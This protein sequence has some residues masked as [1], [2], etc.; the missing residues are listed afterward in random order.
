MTCS[1]LRFGCSRG[2][3][4]VPKGSNYLCGLPC[5]AQVLCE[6]LSPATAVHPVTTMM[7]TGGR[8]LRFVLLLSI[9]S[10]L[11]SAAQLNVLMIAVDDLRNVGTA[12][13]EPE[14][15]MPNLEALA[16]RSTIFT[17]AY[18]QAA[19]C[20]VSRTS[21]LMARRPDT[22]QVIRNEGCPFKTQPEHA[23]WCDVTVSLF[24]TRSLFLTCSFCSPHTSHCPAL[25]HGHCVTVSQC[26][27][28]LSLA[29]SVLLSLARSVCCTVLLS[30]VCPSVGSASVAGYHCLDTSGR[31]VT[32]QWV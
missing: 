30:L 2:V 6:F 15:L 1:T 26:S 19:T 7:M 12:F 9:S 24:F 5:L 13:G 22:T 28:L 21:L 27:V 32:Q 4:R 25:R 29:R 17:N 23:A 18:A 10:G 20:G 16:A 14:A 8:G 11:A 31:V 3:C